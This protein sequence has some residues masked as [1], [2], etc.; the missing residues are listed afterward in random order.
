MKSYLLGMVI[1]AAMLVGVAA[2]GFTHAIECTKPS[3][4]SVESLFVPCH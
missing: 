1:S 2:Y 3:A 4:W